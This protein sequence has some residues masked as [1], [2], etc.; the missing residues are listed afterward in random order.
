AEPT[1]LVRDAAGV[2]T[3]TLNR[4]DA[5]NAFT[6][7][8]HGQLSEALRAAEREPTVRVIVLTGAGRAFCAGQDLKETQRSRAD[9]NGGERP[10]LSG[11]L[12]SHYNV[13]V[14]RLR[15]IEKPIIAAV[16]GV[17]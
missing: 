14:K 11:L 10:R 5:L 16:N 6:R 4:P 15:T 3:L 8:L 12:R 9:G 13:L 1:V 2:R 17:A 7:E